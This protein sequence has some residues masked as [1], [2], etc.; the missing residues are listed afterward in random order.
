MG[1]T[2][3]L[4]SSSLVVNP[5]EQTTCAVQIRNTGS[6][7]DQFSVD[8]V[9]GAES[10]AEVQPPAMNLM[11]GDTGTAVV[12]FAPPRTSEVAAGPMPFGVRV[13]SR[14]D[15]GGSVVE[16]G[17]VDVT[18]F[19]D[20]R[21][22][23]SPVTTHGRSSTRHEIV[24]ENAGNHPLPVELVAGDPEER[25][26]FRVQHPALTVEPGTAAF[27]GLKIRPDK[28]FLKGPER[29]HTFQ[30]TAVH[31]AGPP[32]AVEG[33]F[34][35]RQLLPKWLLPALIALLALVILAVVLWFT[36]LKP[37]VKSAARDAAAAQ[38]SP[39]ASDANAA[40]DVAQSAAKK[41]DD[42]KAAATNP[43]K[44]SNGNGSGTGS[45]QP[46]DGTDTSAWK[47][48]DFRIAS[49]APRTSDPAAFTTFVQDPAPPDGKSMAVT[50][51][52][53]QNPYGDGGV[54]RLMRGDK[55]LLEVGLNNFRDLD[56]HLVQPWLFTPGQKLVMAVSCQTP[57]S[58]NCHP[59]VSFSGRVQN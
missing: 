32:E 51:I 30:V 24:V 10:W 38:V 9:G 17:I 59:A 40:K 43:A 41:A 33:T 7:V 11:P 14:E 31:S 26:R 52:L 6:V 57:A 49:D 22:E 12:R 46:G 48:V 16:E 4:E 37:A 54:I 2:T 5:G 21:L 56:Y 55:V 44:P 53:L 45:G 36:V 28:R 47:P 8:V 29:K 58:G 34:V 39:V 42:A 23:L 13:R 25:L 50:D 15:P 27:V 20:L 19:T 35:Q 3:S 1:V 18:A